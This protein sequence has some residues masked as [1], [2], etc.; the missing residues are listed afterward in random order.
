DVGL[1][2]RPVDVVLVDEQQTARARAIGQG[3]GVRRTEV[4]RWQG[5]VI[6]RVL[7]VRVLPRLVDLYRAREECLPSVRGLL[8]EQV[9]IDGV[10]AVLGDEPD[11]ERAV[12]LDHRV[13]E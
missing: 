8:E 5:V 10:V 2:G 11:V 13:A 6:P 3:R 9:R 1:R 12:R 7:E 4:R